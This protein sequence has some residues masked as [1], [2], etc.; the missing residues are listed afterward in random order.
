MFGI[1]LEL[2]GMINIWFTTLHTAFLI[3]ALDEAEVFSDPPGRI[4]GYCL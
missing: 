2:H 4:I 3:N 1:S